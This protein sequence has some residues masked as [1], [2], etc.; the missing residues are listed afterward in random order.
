MATD[1]RGAGAN[2]DKQNASTAAQDADEDL[3]LLSQA[4]CEAANAETAASAGGALAGRGDATLALRAKRSRAHLG[5]HSSSASS[6]RESSPHQHLRSLRDPF[7]DAAEKLACALEE[8]LAC[9]PPFDEPID[10]DDAHMQSQDA[11]HGMTWTQSQSQQRGAAPVDAFM[12]LDEAFVEASQRVRDVVSQKEEHAEV[13]D[14]AT[15]VAAA[16]ASIFASP[17][18]P[19]PAPRMSLSEQI[20]VMRKV[21]LSSTVERS[22][23]SVRVLLSQLLLPSEAV[24]GSRKPMSA[25]PS[26]VPASIQ[27]ALL[28]SDAL[29][30]A[31]SD[32]R[33]VFAAAAA[34]REAS[35]TA[36]E[37]DA[38]AARLQFDS[39]PAHA[40]LLFWAAFLDAVLSHARVRS[41]L[42]LAL[43]PLLR[44]QGVNET[45][46]VLLALVMR[47][48]EEALTQSVLS[49]L[50]LETIDSGTHTEPAALALKLF[51]CVLTDARQQQ[52]G[53]E[54]VAAALVVVSTSN[55]VVGASSRQ[56][57]LQRLCV[58]HLQLF[59]RSTAAFHWS[60]VALSLL[61]WLLDAASMPL[62]A[63]TDER[64][65]TLAAIVAS[66]DNSTVSAGQLAL[67]YPP[68]DATGDVCSL[69]LACL[70]LSCLNPQ[71]RKQPKAAKPLLVYLSDYAPAHCASST[72]AIKQLLEVAAK[73]TGGP[74]ARK[75]KQLLE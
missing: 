69:L 61:T 46:R 48:H 15:S 23:A 5:A 1:E 3:I 72:P 16:A 18:P 4:P 34:W 42:S 38:A 28:A 56:M 64:L 50:M 57:L 53:T 49:P 27:E 68:G 7:A 10:E 14:A 32:I 36:T 41:L 47:G 73:H 62:L 54:D 26:L 35:L 45:T 51:E 43:L 44:Q 65:P 39:L 19:P 8:E 60:D 31:Y 30:L 63:P 21:L 9:F 70:L 20:D 58:H 75:I 22:Q 13:S 6:S 33:A 52:N 71:L 66:A 25:A 67:L 59:E 24:S 11:S 37:F 12:S 29:K 17:P 2:A 74:I 40:Q 55:H